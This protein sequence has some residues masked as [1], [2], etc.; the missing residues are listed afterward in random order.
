[1]APAS[2]RAKRAYPSISAVRAV[3][4]MS[5][6]L[7]AVLTADGHDLQ[8][9][10]GVVR[11]IIRYI[12][13]HAPR[14]AWFVSQHMTARN[15]RPLR[16]ARFDCLEAATH[17]ALAWEAQRLHRMARGL[18]GASSVADPLEAAIA[19]V[20]RAADDMVTAKQG[21]ARLTRPLGPEATS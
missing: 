13:D 12:P 7:T 16:T 2:E 6:A 9:D 18:A 8:D 19:A 4:V 21:L 11:A 14:G 10:A 3:H 17:Q 20:D 1:M 15:V 5:T